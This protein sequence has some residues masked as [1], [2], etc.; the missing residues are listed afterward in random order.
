[1]LENTFCHIPG[2]GEKTE[3]SLWAS[4]VLSWRD[5][6]GSARWPLSADKR[7]TLNEVAGAS[8][9]RLAANDIGFFY[10]KLPTREHWRLFRNFRDSVAYLDIETT[11]LSGYSNYITTIALYDG[12]NIRYYVHE[13]NMHEFATDIEQY[14]LL[15]SYNGKTFD[16]PFIRSYLG[17]PMNQPHI[18]LRYVL[19]QLGHRGGLKE[20][21]KHF[22]IDREEL[23]GVDGY[24]AVL[25]WYDFYTNGNRKALETLLAYNITDVVNLE[26]LMTLAYNLKLRDTPF[27]SV[28]ALPEPQL[29]PIPFKPDMPTVEKIR[30]KY[31]GH[32]W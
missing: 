23:A 27:A 2:I 30:N 10:D 4:G 28:Y 26:L 9:A 29:I 11:G 14:A 24:F 7:K 16:I 21:E 18:D 22:G 13:E 3:R 17:I 5:A 20:C 32:S 15:V 8:A 12:R 1:M 6:G 31:D 19:A 25:L